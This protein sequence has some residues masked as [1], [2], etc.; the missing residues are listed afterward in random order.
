MEEKEREVLRKIEE[1][2][3]SRRDFLKGAFTATAGGLITLS[4]IGIA[5]PDLAMAQGK[6]RAQEKPKVP[7]KEIFKYLFADRRNCT[8]CRSC[9]YACS[10]KHEKIVRPAV[11]A[12]HVK[13]YW[14]IIDVPNIC[15]Q[16][17]DPAPCIKACPT[18]PVAI[19][20]E[21]KHNGIT[22]IDNKTCLGGKCNK[23]IEACPPQFLRRHPETGWPIFCD[24]CEGDPECVKACKAQATNITTCLR[25]EKNPNALT[26]SY[27]EVKS[28][29]A[30]KDLLMDVFYPSKG[31]R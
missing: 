3:P 9:E 19:Q 15:F 12:I 31:G 22:F 11:A 26:Y 30:A 23:C 20:R 2:G 17:P 1:E 4:G 18:T 7:E 29:D 16:C 8:G 13:R 27:M 10:L 28:T 14:G 25:A 6:A 21:P 24:T 5:R